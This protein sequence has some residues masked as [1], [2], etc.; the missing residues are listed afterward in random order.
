MPESFAAETA[1]M[2][3]HSSGNPLV[4]ARLYSVDVFAVPRSQMFFDGGQY[5]RT[6][7]GPRILVDDRLR[8][9]DVV[10][11]VAHELAH[12]LV[13]LWRVD[14]DDEETFCARV[15]VAWLTGLVD[16]L[17]RSASRIKKTHLL[18][19]DEAREIER[20]LDDGLV[21]G[22]SGAA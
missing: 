20:P 5:I 21:L 17:P 14:T 10:E 3:R 2:V 15:A 7:S 4:L 16:L 22:A 8:G 1:M 9:T 18:P 19:L 12:H 13:W 6:P 11:V